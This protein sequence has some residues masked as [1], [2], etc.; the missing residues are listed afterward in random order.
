MRL[1]PIR[2]LLP[3]VLFLA[4]VHYSGRAQP[5][6]PDSSA[7]PARDSMGVWV[8]AALVVEKDGRISKVDIVENS[9]RKC[10]KRLKK[11]IE[12]E[13]LRIV[14]AAPRMEPR[15]DKKGNPQVT[16]YKQPIVFKIASEADETN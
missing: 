13:V 10:D 12:A 8:V 5:P 14:R 1:L 9:C 4:A 3:L 16:Y 7:S 15:K 11:S 2:R 6:V